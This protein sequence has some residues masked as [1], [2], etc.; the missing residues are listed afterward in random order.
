MPANYKIMINYIFFSFV[1]AWGILGYLIRPLSGVSLV[2][3][4]V[5]IFIT[6]AI[7]ALFGESS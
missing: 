1:I 4:L 3:F 7:R 6:V 5:P 2:L